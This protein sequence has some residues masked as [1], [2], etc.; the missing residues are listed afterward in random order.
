MLRRFAFSFVAVAM[1][2]AP[3]AASAQSNPVVVELFSSQGCSS[4]PPADAYL[5]ELAKDPNVL[6]L[7]F[8]VDY[9][10]RLGWKDTLG[11]NA[12]TQRQYAYSKSLGNRM[13]WTP[14]FIVDGEEYTRGN[15]RAMVR[16]YVEARKGRAPQAEITIRQSGGGYVATIK[17]LSSGLS[18]SDIM[19]VAYTALQDVAIKRGENAGLTIR[20]VNTVYQWERLAGWNGRNTVDVRVSGN[21]SPPFAILVQEA[22]LGEYLAAQAV[23]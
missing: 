7:A 23:R 20:Y 11:S 3:L 9:W 19:L 13:V 2:F 8:H 14:Q 6:P 17:P 21:V 12:N 18:S 15:F 1:S 4:C 10:D 16:E 22:G 5:E